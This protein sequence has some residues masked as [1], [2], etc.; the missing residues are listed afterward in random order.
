[1]NYNAEKAALDMADKRTKQLLRQ[2][3]E[4]NRKHTVND[5]HFLCGLERQTKSLQPSA[6]FLYKAIGMM[7]SPLMHNIRFFVCMFCRKQL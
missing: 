4:Q 3:L 7:R 1:M 2:T 6:S 5:L